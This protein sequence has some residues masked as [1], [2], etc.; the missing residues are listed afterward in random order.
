MD[1][2][3]WRCLVEGCGHQWSARL[4]F[5]TR[6]VKPSGCPECWRGRPAPPPD[7]CGHEFDGAGCRPLGRDLRCG[8]RRA[9]AGWARS[10]YGPVGCCT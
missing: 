1:R 6:T 7:R 3:Q 4:Q 2:C 9:V 8:V 5:R 10:A